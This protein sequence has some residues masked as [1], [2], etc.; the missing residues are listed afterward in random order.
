MGL[1]NW[2]FA[3]HLPTIKK[4]QIKQPSFEPIINEG[5]GK[6]PC[7]HPDVPCHSRRNR[8]RRSLLPHALVVFVQERSSSPLCHCCN[9][10][11]ARPACVPRMEYQVRS[12]CPAYSGCGRLGLPMC[13]EVLSHTMMWHIHKVA[14]PH[15]CPVFAHTSSPTISGNGP[16]YCFKIRSIQ[17]WGFPQ[18]I[19]L[20][21]P[22]PAAKVILDP[23]TANPCLLLSKDQ[24]SVRRGSEAQKLPKHPERFDHCPVVLGCEGFMEG[25]HFWEFSVGSENGWS[26]GVIKKSVN[27]KDRLNFRPEGGIWAMGRCGEGHFVY[28][29]SKSPLRLSQELKS[30]RVCLNHPEGHVAFFDGDRSILLYEFTGA[31]FQGG[32]LFPFFHVFENGHICL[33]P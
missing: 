31:S 3:S 29:H 19:L 28:T 8:K 15:S 22:S 27:R 20:L 2:C 14:H 25:C 9:Q 32:T 18:I 26:V 1:G 24:K 23:N 13:S 12:V 11:S 30:I 5:E 33:T 7:P 21:S 10:L 4:G 17:G 16:F 6:R